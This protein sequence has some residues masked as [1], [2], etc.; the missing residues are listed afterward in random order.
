MKNASVWGGPYEQHV[1]CVSCEISLSHLVESR[2]SDVVD[3]SHHVGA[4]GLMDG[5][6]AGSVSQAATPGQHTAA[7]GRPV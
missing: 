5:A 3:A 4:G 1:L 6:A 7:G 2:L